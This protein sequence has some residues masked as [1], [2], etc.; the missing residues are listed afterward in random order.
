MEMLLLLR[1]CPVARSSSHPCSCIRGGGVD[2]VRPRR[3]QVALHQ[4]HVVNGGGAQGKFLALGVERLCACSVTGLAGRLVL[5]ARL[6]HADDGVLDVP[7]CTWFFQPLQP[8]LLLA[9]G[10]FVGDDLRLR[11]SGCG[12]GTLRL[13]PMGVVREVARKQLRKYRAVAPNKE[14][15]GAAREYRRAPPAVML[16]CPASALLAKP[17]TASSVGSRALREPFMVSSWLR[18][19]IRLCASSGRGGPA[20]A[21]S[22][23]A[24]ARRVPRPASGW[25]RWG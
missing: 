4:D 9:V 17:A 3:L 11:E 12:W 25:R 14:G 16:G 10:E 23:P 20:P 19:W 7:P 15:G 8:E 5:R 1:I 24:R 2:L 13:K 21:P 22:G 6:R 18:S